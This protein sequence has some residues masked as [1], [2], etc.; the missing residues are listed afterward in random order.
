[1]KLTPSLL[2]LL[3]F[4]PYP[5]SPFPNYKLSPHSV[6]L[7]LFFSKCTPFFTSFLSFSLLFSSYQSFSYSFSSSFCLTYCISSSSPHIFLFYIATYF[8]P[9]TPSSFFLFLLVLPLSFLSFSFSFI[10]FLLFHTSFPSYSPFLPSFPFFS[11]SALLFND[12]SPFA[13][14]SPPIYLYPFDS[15]SFFLLLFLLLILFCLLYL[16]CTY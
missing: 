15:L 7:S 13:C 5:P 8:P 11:S 16:Y 12:P 9:S 3:L 6:F 4:L 2:P 14:H 10:D 1:M